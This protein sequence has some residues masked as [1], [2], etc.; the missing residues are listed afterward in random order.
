MDWKVIIVCGKSVVREPARKGIGRD[1][2]W[3]GLLRQKEV[4]RKAHGGHELLKDD[5]RVAEEEGNW[6]LVV[7]RVPS[8]SESMNDLDFQLLCSELH[9]LH[10]VI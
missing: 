8:A 2:G 10:P 4:K 7:Y 5:G 1:G 3:L 9:A 6:F